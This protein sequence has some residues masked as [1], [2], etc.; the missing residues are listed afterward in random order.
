MTATERE[1]R[2]EF[3]GLQ[4]EVL[5]ADGS[6]AVHGESLKLELLMAPNDPKCRRVRITDGLH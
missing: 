2:V 3:C 4:A 1:A 5:H 6:F